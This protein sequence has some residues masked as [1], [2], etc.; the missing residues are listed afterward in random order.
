MCAYS[1]DLRER[2]LRALDQGRTCSEVA[3]LFGIS[4]TTV[5]RDRRLHRE[6]GHL[7]AQSP[8]GRPR[9]IAPSDHT[10][11]LEQLT[12]APDVTLEEHCQRWEQSHGIRITPSTMCRAIQRLGWSSKQESRRQ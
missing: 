6:Q 5:G 4:R 10:A 2:V 7:R 12:T 3:H 9:Q 8:P 11:L 1:R